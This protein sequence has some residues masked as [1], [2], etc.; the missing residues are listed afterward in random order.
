MSDIRGEIRFSNVH[1]WLEFIGV[2]FG[3]EAYFACAVD[4]D[5]RFLVA[6]A[7][8]IGGTDTVYFI[9]VVVVVVVDVFFRILRFSK[10]GKERR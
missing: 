3:V 9:V 1:G 6:V 2:H 5:G 7:I 8:F 4:F 10:G